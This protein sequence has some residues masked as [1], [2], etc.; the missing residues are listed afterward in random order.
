MISFTISDIWWIN[1][2]AA[3]CLGCRILIKFLFFVFI[4]L[5]WTGKHVGEAAGHYLR[6]NSVN[7]WGCI[8]LNE[9]VPSFLYACDPRNIRLIGLLRSYNTFLWQTVTWVEGLGRK[10]CN[11]MGL[12]LL[13]MLRL[14][15][16]GCSLYPWLRIEATICCVILLGG[17]RVM[18]FILVGRRLLF[19]HNELV[20]F[21]QGLTVNQDSAWARILTGL[22]RTGNYRWLLVSSIKHCSLRQQLSYLFISQLLWLKWLWLPSIHRGCGALPIIEPTVFYIISILIV[23]VY[24]EIFKRSLPYL[25]IHFLIILILVEL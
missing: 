24:E 2:V 3:S 11:F 15:L 12:D 17:G 22:L 20:F 4:D 5:R 10:G 18:L 9:L 25:F 21:L 13:H 7:F 1:N 19:C 23:A 8:L 16:Y 6:L 14:K